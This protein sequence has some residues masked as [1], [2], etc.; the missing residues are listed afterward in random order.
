MCPGVDRQDVHAD[1]VIWNVKII[2]I[3][4]A[5]G[6]SRD[7]DDTSVVTEVIVFAMELQAVILN[8]NEL[9][10]VLYRLGESN[11]RIP[12]P[13]LLFNLRESTG[14]TELLL[15]SPYH[16]VLIYSEGDGVHI[17]DRGNKT[18]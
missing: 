14:R 10:P 5:L 4:E 17:Y 7:N 6:P 1:V 3:H 15:G 12:H 18:A 13:Y 11:S 16:L 8:V 9:L 2:S